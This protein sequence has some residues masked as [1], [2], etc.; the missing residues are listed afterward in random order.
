MIDEFYEKEEKL[1]K[2]LKGSRR[3]GRREGF[4]N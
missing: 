2:W 3:R 1:E 4:K